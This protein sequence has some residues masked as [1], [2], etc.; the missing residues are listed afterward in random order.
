[1]QFADM[2][3][4][5]E[6]RAGKP[7]PQIFGEEGEPRF[8]KLESAVLA[9]LAAL[10]GRVV[11][12]GGGLPVQHENRELMARTGLVIRLRASP[13]SIHARLTRSEGSR[14]RALRPLLGGDAPVERIRRLLADREAA[15]AT[16]HV[17]IDTDGKTPRD[18]VRE[19][20]EAWREHADAK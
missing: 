4:M 7:I 10:G 5:I 13:E 12:T 15:Y 19:I 9:E 6:Q 2:D 14:G 8:R 1:M 17:T 3:E 20:V 16:A 11:S 18:V